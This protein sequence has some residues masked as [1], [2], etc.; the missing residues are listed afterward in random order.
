MSEKRAKKDA[1]TG[2]I[3]LKRG[4]EIGKGRTQANK[5]YVWAVCP[6]CEGGRYIS[7][8]SGVK[9]GEQLARQRCGPCARQEMKKLTFRN[10]GGS[11]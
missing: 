2:D 6:A 9:K 1:T 4:W 10:H 5:L 7:A 11:G 8:Y 3:L